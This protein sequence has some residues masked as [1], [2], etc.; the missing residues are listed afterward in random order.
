MFSVCVPVD[1]WG[2]V[3][4]EVQLGASALRVEDERCRLLTW[5]LLSLAPVTS[6]HRH[7]Q[8]PS[9]FLHSHFITPTSPV[10][11]L[12]RGSPRFAFI[13]S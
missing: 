5:L 11:M 8:F 12:F 10:L 2:P 1:T 3:L 13:Y 6:P 7:R 4:Q 9:R